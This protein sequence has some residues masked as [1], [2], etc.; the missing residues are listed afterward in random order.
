MR[1]TAEPLNL[2]PVVLAE[3]VSAD[4]RVR[5]QARIGEDR[6]RLEVVGIVEPSPTPTTIEHLSQRELLELLGESR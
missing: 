5:W 4:G 6:G 2:A 3:R 1:M